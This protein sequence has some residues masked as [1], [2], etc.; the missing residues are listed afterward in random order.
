MLMT[1]FVTAVHTQ[2]ALALVVLAKNVTRK[3]AI[4]FVSIAATVER[5]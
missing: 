4:V 5:S 3:K 2:A 1:K